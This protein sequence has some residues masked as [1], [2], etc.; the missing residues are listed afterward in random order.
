MAIPGRIFQRLGS[1]TVE[2]APLA[3]DGA[4]PLRRFHGSS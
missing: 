1:V 3:A 4:F 2:Q